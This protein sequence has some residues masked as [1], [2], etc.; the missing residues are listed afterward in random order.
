M[1]NLISAIVFIL[2]IIPIAKADY[3]K[4]VESLGYVSGTGLAC[5]A[6]YYPAYETIVRSYILSAA[7]SDEEQE[8]GMRV[9]NAAKAEAFISKQQDDLWDCYELNERFNKQEILKTKVYKDG[10]LK[11]PKGEIIKPRQAYD[12]RLVYDRTRN[13]REHFMELYER[14]IAEQKLQAQKQGIYEKIRRAEMTGR[15]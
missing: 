13:E 3:L 4:E 10:R 8:K 9:F 15:Y 2:A 5:D 1:K 6:E 14:N 7:R 12:P 11:M